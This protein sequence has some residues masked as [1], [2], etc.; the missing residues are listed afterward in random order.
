MRTRHTKPVLNT[1]SS[2]DEL[3]SKTVVAVVSNEANSP[4]FTVNSAMNISKQMQITETVTSSVYSKNNFMRITTLLYG[5]DGN[6]VQNIQEGYSGTF[7]IYEPESQINVMYDNK[8]NPIIIGDESCTSKYIAPLETLTMGPFGGYAMTCNTSGI[9]MGGSNFNGLVKIVELTNKL[10][11]LVDEINALKTYIAS[12]T[13]TC[14]TPGSP[15]TQP[16]SPFTGNFTS[17]NK[18]DYENT[19]I[20][21]GD[22]VNDTTT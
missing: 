9:F 2:L 16:V 7:D 12:H 11:A 10:N 6:V 4:N 1:S 3:L 13:H 14:A 21:H 22:E 15:S 5:N 18:S 20:K 17:F 8:N 19:I